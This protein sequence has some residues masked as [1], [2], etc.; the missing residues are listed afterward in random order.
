VQLVDVSL[1]AFTALRNNRELI[2]SR[3]RW[4]GGKKKKEKSI[5]L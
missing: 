4:R 5:G 3:P 2:G 1:G